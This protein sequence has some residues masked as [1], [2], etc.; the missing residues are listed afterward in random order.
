V[1][2]RNVHKRCNELTNEMMT[3][4]TNSTVARGW[5]TLVSVLV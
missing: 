5:K 4:Q 3:N 2:N 1:T